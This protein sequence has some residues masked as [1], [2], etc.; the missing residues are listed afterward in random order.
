[1][2]HLIYGQYLDYMFQTPTTR[3]W[4]KLYDEGKLH[5]PQTH[6][7]E[8]KAPEEL[9]DLANDPDEVK[10]L[11]G[12][13]A[14]AQKVAELRKAQR[15]HLLRIRDAGFL[16]EAEQHS[17][18]GS[19]SIYDLAHD[20]QNYPLEKILAM[21]ELASSLKPEALP[22]LKKGLKGNDSGVRY[23]AALGFLMRGSPA[24][25]EESTAL[26]ACLHDA[27]PT[28]QIV[29]A[30]ALAQYG[31]AS[32]RVEALEV[33]KR[34][35]PPNQNGAYVSMAALNAIDNLGETAAGL[36]PFLKNIPEEDP[37]APQRAS[38]YTARL[39]ERLQAKQP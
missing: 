37:K 10:N 1:M 19:G 27:S 34:L 36:L 17:R 28:V 7:W 20:Q 5:P 18:A 6:F 26:Q 35:A 15:E 30:Q 16:S 29:G 12:D 33:L 4:K 21:A 3:V 9:Y 22:E 24:V 2:P 39:L 25:S 13:K 11:A 32:L 14:H 38:S 8:R 23:W 31:P